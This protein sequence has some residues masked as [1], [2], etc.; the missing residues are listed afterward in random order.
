[1]KRRDNDA[2]RA[3][4]LIWWEGKGASGNNCTILDADASRLASLLVACILPVCA[5][6]A[7][8]QAGASTPMIGALISA[9]VLREARFAGPTS[10]RFAV[11]SKQVVGRPDS[12]P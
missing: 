8:C 10:T 7:P 9:R 6:L 4:A 11:M 1:M 3:E 2:A 5:L 12:Q